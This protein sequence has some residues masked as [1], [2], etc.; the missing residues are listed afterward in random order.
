MASHSIV[1]RLK[2]IYIYI[3]IHPQADSMWCA[4]IWPLTFHSL[5]EDVESFCSDMRW[6]SCAHGSKSSVF[7]LSLLRDSN[8]KFCQRRTF[9][10]PKM[11]LSEGKS[12]AAYRDAFSS[13][14]INV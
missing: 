7:P 13:K 12:T 11:N 4:D 1:V 14:E 3:Y 2:H 6:F 10:I 9:L 5:T 8:V